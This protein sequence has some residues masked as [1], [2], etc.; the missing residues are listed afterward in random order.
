MAIITQKPDIKN[1]W[2]YDGSRNQPSIDE[3]LIGWIQQIPPHERANWIEYRQDLAIKYLFQEG[4]A[5]WDAS[6]EYGINSLTK[7]NGVVYYS[8][9]ADNV[10]NQPDTDTIH[11]EVAF[12]RAGSSASVKETVDRI[13]TEEGFLDLYVSKAVPVMTG[14]AKAPE[15]QATAS[16]GHTFQGDGENTGLF[17]N[18]NNLPEVKFSNTT[19]ATFNSNPSTTSSDDTVVTVAVLKAALSTL[20][21]ALYPVGISIVTQNGDN[22]SSYLGFGQWEQDCQG[23]AI[24]GVTTDVTANSPD[25]VKNVN[26]EFGEYNHTL[27][28]DVD[29]WGVGSEELGTAPRGTLITG[30]GTAERNEKLESVS[31]ANQNKSLEQSAVQPS[32]TKYIWTRIS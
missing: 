7:Y 29:N 22:P 21:N 1:T 14:I 17:L 2:A 9:T 4:F 27:V 30:T 19:I 20:Q 28:I 10:A 18:A 6:F 25:W 24:V 11:W 15:F 16:G 31:F 12:D 3:I 13:L 8:L 26:Q 5:E 23:R 32:K